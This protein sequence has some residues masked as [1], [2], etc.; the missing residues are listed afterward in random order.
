MPRYRIKKIGYPRDDNRTKY[1][2]YVQYKY[3][4]WPFWCTETSEDNHEDASARMKNLVSIANRHKTVD[5]YYNAEPVPAHIP[6]EQKDRFL[7]EKE[8]GT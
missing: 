1:W 2:Y 3:R 6:V 4:Y 8:K 5:F 7:L